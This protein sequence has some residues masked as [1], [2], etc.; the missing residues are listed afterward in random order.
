MEKNEYERLNKKV[1]RRKCKVTPHVSK[2]SK[3]LLNKLLKRIANT[4][5]FA[6]KR[7]N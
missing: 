5:K 2:V 1:F 3:L 4:S 7:N 6:R